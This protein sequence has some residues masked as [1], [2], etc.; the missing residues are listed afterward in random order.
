MCRYHWGNSKSHQILTDDI[1]LCSWYRF[2]LTWPHTTITIIT[3][4]FLVVFKPRNV[5][6][7]QDPL[8]PTIFFRLYEWDAKLSNS[9]KQKQK[10]IPNS[11][12]IKTLFRK[13]INF[14]FFETLSLYLISKASARAISIFFNYLLLPTKN[15]RFL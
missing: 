7:R 10:K 8:N 2:Q 15:R 6:L 14:L 1:F 13:T 4:P 9:R 3:K 12:S 11:L 5:V